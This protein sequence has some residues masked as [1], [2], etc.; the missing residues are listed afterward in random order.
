M[1]SG[2]RLITPEMV[3]A[4]ERAPIKLNYITDTRYF[5]ELT[6]FARNSDLLVCEGMY[7]DDEYNEKMTE[8][9]HMVFSQSAAIAADSGSRKLWLTHYSPA[10]KEPQQYERQV[11]SIFPETVIS[12]DG[13]RTVLK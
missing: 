2:G 7:G 6:E 1:A 11:R 5:V 4:G 10:L 13:E 12:T 9:G 3:T 8:K